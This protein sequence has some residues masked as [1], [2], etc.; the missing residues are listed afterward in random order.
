MTDDAREDF[1]SH[2][3]TLHQQESYDEVLTLVLERYGAKLAGFQLKML[4]RNHSL[5]EESWSMFLEDAWKGL[6]KFQWRSRLKT[7]L[8]CLAR[9]AVCRLTRQPRFKVREVTF[10]ARLVKAAAQ[11]FTTAIG[12]STAEDRFH[13][14]FKRLPEEDQWICAMRVGCNLSWKQ[15]AEVVNEWGDSAVEEEA[16]KT[17][18]TRLRNRFNRLQKRMREWASEDG[19]RLKS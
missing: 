5:A 9:N 10:S 14:Y 18:C 6:P 2:L 3:Q 17:E 16:M 11:T 4:D 13:A 8:F 15:V 12:L 7:W 1:E 19:L